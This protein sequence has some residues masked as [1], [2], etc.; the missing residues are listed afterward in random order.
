MQRGRG[1]GAAQP[2]RGP[3]LA[4][5]QGG[6]PG[7][8]DTTHAHAVV[9]A[10]HPTWRS[11]ARQEP[12]AQCAHMLKRTHAL[13]VKCTSPQSQPTPAAQLG[14]S[15]PVPHKPQRRARAQQRG[16]L[17]A[18]KRPAGGLVGEHVAPLGCPHGAPPP[19]PVPAG[20]VVVAL[21]LLAYHQLPLVEQRPPGT[22]PSVPVHPGGRRRREPRLLD[23]AGVHLQQRRVHI[24]QRW[25]CGEVSFSNAHTH[26]TR[27]CPPVMRHSIAWWCPV[28]LHAVP[29]SCI[30]GGRAAHAEV[31]AQV[32]ATWR[33]PPRACISSWVHSWQLPVV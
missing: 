13:D 30:T 6:T 25:P 20:A 26:H 31:R 17:K 12:E 1:C 7:L 28:A 10:L 33:P 18:Q 9:E 24:L 22:E 5:T 8:G 2:T 21:A 14:A 27:R 4:G 3:R 16:G 32:K 11:Q 29:T 19:S 23:S 15:F